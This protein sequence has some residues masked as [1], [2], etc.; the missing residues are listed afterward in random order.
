[1]VHVN[2]ETH[3]EV[4]LHVHIF[5]ILNE[6]EITERFEFLLQSINHEIFPIDKEF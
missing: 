3:T 1:M 6:R 4:Y 5:S 2:T